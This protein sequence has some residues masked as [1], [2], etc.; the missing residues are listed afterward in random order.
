MGA[1]KGPGFLVSQSTQQGSDQTQ[2]C[3]LGP[4]CLY[5]TQTLPGP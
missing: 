5:P 1:E 3:L 2:A 4:W